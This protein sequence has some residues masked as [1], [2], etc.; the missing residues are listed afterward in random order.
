KTEAK[1]IERSRKDEELRGKQISAIRREQTNEAL[2]TI[3][4]VRVSRGLSIDGPGG[5]NIRRVNRDRARENENA[6]VLS[7]KNRQ[8]TLKTQAAMKRR[9]A[10]FA[11][12]SG[13]A[14]A[15]SSLAT[16]EWG[17]E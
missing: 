13:F 9:A 2:A 14:S 3:D 11:V 8:E 15:A 12:L 5:V 4:A 17:G 16:V 7:S 6:E 10:P 1:Q